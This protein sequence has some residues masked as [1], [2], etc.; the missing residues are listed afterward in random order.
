MSPQHELQWPP[1]YA[2]NFAR[3]IYQSS[4]RPVK[5]VAVAALLGLL[6]G[7]CGRRYSISNTGLNLYVILV[8]R[9]GIGKETLHSGIGLMMDQARDVHFAG[10]FVDFDDMVSGPALQKAIL[11]KPSFVNVAGEFGRKLRGMSSDKDGPMQTLRTV[12]TNAYSKSGPNDFLGGIRY[13]NS[14]DSKMGVKG[15]A[16]SLVGETTPDTLFRSLTHS[17]MEDGFLSRFTIVEF[18]GERPPPN[19]ARACELETDELHRWKAILL[20]ASEAAQPI[21]C[22]ARIEVGYKDMP[23]AEKLEA[24]GLE[25]DR[26]I[27]A[28]LDEGRRQMWN[29]A[30]IKVLRI[31]A[32]LAIADNEVDPRI[33]LGHAAWAMTLIKRDIAT[34]SARMDAGD[35]GSDD[36]VRM[37]LVRAAIRDYCK[38]DYTGSYNVL[39]GM[40]DE[41]LVTYTFIQARMRQKPAFRDHPQGSVKALDITLQGLLDGGYIRKADPNVLLD[42]FL[43]SGR[44]FMLASASI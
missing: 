3:F 35:V 44:C 13:S 34:M 9:S 33:D 26:Q 5:E 6:A 28:T 39:P 31:A 27:N 32:L 40:R 1:G 17:M 23:T 29:R 24:F 16:F 43:F 11:M 41:G 20:R 4:P 42:K 38:K 36:N 18:T 7:V 2:G 12:M 10:Q 8:A 19:E 21:N 22:P 15:A 14:D 25:C 30:H 37:D